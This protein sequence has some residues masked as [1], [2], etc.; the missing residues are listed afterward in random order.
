MQRFALYRSVI[1][2]VSQRGGT[3]IEQRRISNRLKHGLDVRKR[4]VA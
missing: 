3:R 4:A 2:P 1:T